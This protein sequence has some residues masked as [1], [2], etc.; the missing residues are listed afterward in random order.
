[1]S[2]KGDYCWRSP[3]RLKYG[4]TDPPPGSAGRDGRSADRSRHVHGVAN[5]VRHIHQ[6]RIAPHDRAQ[7]AGHVSAVQIDVSSAN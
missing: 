7:I 5:A 2:G 4:C 3:S 1:M 6:R